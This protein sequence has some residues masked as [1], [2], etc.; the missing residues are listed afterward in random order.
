MSSLA[1]I[2]CGLAGYRREQIEPMF[3]SAPTNALWPPEW[4]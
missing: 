4:R 1:P 3:N 2:G